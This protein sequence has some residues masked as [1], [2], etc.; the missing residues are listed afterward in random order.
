[1]SSE[2]KIFGSDFLRHDFRKEATHHGRALKKEGQIGANC[3]Q[4]LYRFAYSPTE[5][6][7][8]ESEYRRLEYRKGYEEGQTAKRCGLSIPQGEILQEYEQEN[9]TYAAQNSEDYYKGLAAGYEA[10]EEAR[11]GGQSGSY[12]EQRETGRPSSYDQRYTDRGFSE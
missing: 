6:T 2:K 5:V 11:Q 3:N 10:E 8:P 4:Y 9:S 1:M 12:A 7:L